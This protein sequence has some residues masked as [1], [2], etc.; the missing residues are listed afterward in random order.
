MKLLLDTHTFLWWDNA[1]DRLSATAL[2]ALRDPA[3]DL[4]LSAA[5]AWEILIKSHLGKLTCRL[6]IADMIANQ[7][8]NG[9][10]VLPVD[11]HHVLGIDGLPPIHKDPFDRLLAAQ[12]NVEGATFVT[13]DPIFA[14]YPVRTLW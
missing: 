12:A 14:Q 5:S 8:S 3:N 9:V 11:I 7:Q 1:P 10:K 2:S 6:P 4:Y 13:A